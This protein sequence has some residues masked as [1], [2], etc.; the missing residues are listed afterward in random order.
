MTQRIKA[1]VKETVGQLKAAW[2]GG[3]DVERGGGGSEWE[4]RAR[5]AEGKP[6][7]GAL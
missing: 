2:E 4:P 3:Q 1:M 7:A 6:R 5:E